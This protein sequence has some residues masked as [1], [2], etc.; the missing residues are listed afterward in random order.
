[1]QYVVRWF[2]KNTSY[3]PWKFFWWTH[4]DK[5]ESSSQISWG[6]W[7][8]HRNLVERVMA[9]QG[10]R[11]F[12]VGL[13]CLLCKL[14][15]WLICWPKRLHEIVEICIDLPRFT[16][17]LSKF[18]ENC[19]DMF[20]YFTCVSVR[21]FQVRQGVVVQH[22]RENEVAKLLKLWDGS[23]MHQRAWRAVRETLEN[24]SFLADKMVERDI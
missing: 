19:S 17:F 11:H 9:R 3:S 5:F 16:I 10:E 2:Q 24:L 1:M 7:K 22:G 23:K 8:M 13:L 12:F 14:R 4:F 6:S 15:I 21:I 18:E 20:T